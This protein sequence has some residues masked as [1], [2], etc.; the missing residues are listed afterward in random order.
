MRTASEEITDSFGWTRRKRPRIEQT[1]SQHILSVA[2]DTNQYFLSI[3]TDI[4]NYPL[5]SLK[6]PRSSTPLYPPLTARNAAELSTVAEL[7]WLK[8][9]IFFIFSTKILQEI[10]KRCIFAAWKISK[11]CILA[12]LKISKRCKWHHY[13]A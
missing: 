6:H 9:I 8:T 3:V 7:I 10:S 12:A 5:M 4:I 2:I 11:R 13:E 1:A